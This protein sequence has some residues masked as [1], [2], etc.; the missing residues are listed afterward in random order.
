MSLL[1]TDLQEPDI[2]QELANILVSKYF[3]NAQR[4]SEFLSFVVESTLNGNASQL[5]GYTI[6][7]EVYGRPVSFDPKADTIVR[8]SACRVRAKLREY[9][10]SPVGR[11]SR[12]HILMPDGSY[13]P[14]FQSKNIDP[15][16]DI[17]TSAKPMARSYARHFKFVAFTF[18]LIAG[19]AVTSILYNLNAL[20]SGHE[21]FDRA[22]TEQ[23]MLSMEKELA[24]RLNQ[25]GDS[26][27][28][29][30]N[31]DEAIKHYRKAAK[32]DPDNREYRQ[33][34]D[35]TNI[36]REKALNWTFFLQWS[37]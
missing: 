29:F 1:T 5:K 13:K 31:Y 16:C 25:I 14:Q 33:R 9:Y 3:V 23:D 36:E 22:L 37:R 27:Y 20:D 2:R 12:I 4:M 8:V 10:D 34:I 24:N 21:S 18:T 26:Y 32:F 15:L 7:V 30:G 28:Q 17:P 35:K 19:L 6:G 11:L